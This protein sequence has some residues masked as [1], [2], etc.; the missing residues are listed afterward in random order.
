MCDGDGRERHGQGVMDCP[1]CP[2]LIIGGYSDLLDHVRD[3]HREVAME[4]GE[5]GET[6]LSR[7]Q[8]AQERALARDI[9][10]RMVVD[11]DE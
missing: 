1:E 5:N 11:G 2:V 8:T 10:N 6:L 3:E 9:E 4:P 7:I